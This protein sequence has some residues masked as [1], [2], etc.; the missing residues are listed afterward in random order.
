MER[1]LPL[2]VV[3]K[4]SSNV[5]RV[6]SGTGGGMS[7][8]DMIPEE[9]NDMSLE[10]SEE[11]AVGAQLSETTQVLL[12][13]KEENAKLKANIGELNEKVKD[14]EAKAEGS[15][16]VKHT[17]SRGNSL[18][19]SPHVSSR[20]SRKQNS[21]GSQVSRRENSM[22]QSVGRGDS[23]RTFSDGDF[24]TASLCFEDTWDLASFSA[25]L[26]GAP[27]PG[28]PLPGMPLPSAPFPG[29]CHSQFPSSFPDGATPHMYPPMPP[30][31]ALGFAAMAG[32]AA[33]MGGQ[34]PP[35]F[36]GPQALQPPF[37]RD[38]GQYPT[39]APRMQ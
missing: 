32:F 37:P 3:R 7:Q 12:R 28:M 22:K 20:A 23:G 18:K 33:A 38:G 30:P 6:R 39:S 19:K 25:P 1:T 8:P 34:P 15:P 10:M 14:A 5:R 11:L 35:T 21:M 4:Q 36:P 17:Q 16:H 24:G 26:P 31:N 27:L 9:E 2:S 29:A 13:L